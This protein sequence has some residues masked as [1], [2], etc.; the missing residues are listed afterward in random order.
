MMNIQPSTH[1]CRVQ[2]AASD[3][4]VTV[5][6]R[7]LRERKDH[8]EAL[9]VTEFRDQRDC[10]DPLDPPDPLATP[11]RAFS[12]VEEETLTISRRLKR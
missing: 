3:H 6:N 7:D 12:T 5:D 2:R 8:E 4:P 11:Q 10:K 1:D 9:A